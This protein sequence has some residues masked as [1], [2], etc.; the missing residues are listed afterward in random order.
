MPSPQA[1]PIHLSPLQQGGTGG[2]LRLALNWKGRSIMKFLLTSAG[3]SNDNIRNALVDLLGKPIAGACALC[4]P[5]AAHA[6]PEGPVEAWRQIRAWG[7]LGWNALGMLEL[8]ALPSIRLE[9]WLPL[10]QAADALLVCSRLT[11]RLSPV[12]ELHIG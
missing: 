9:Q 3:I 2:D 5:T 7:E 12:R 8:S 10:L 4:I 6:I 11:R 1:S